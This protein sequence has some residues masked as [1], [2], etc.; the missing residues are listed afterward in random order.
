MQCVSCGT[1]IPSNASFCPKCG[2]K[3]AGSL[4]KLSDAAAPSPTDMLR[5]PD[6]GD[7]IEQTLW[8]GGYSGKAMIG[9]WLAGAI[10]TAG[11]IVAAVMFSE[12]WM[13]FAGVIAVIWVC[14]LFTFAYR[15]LNLHY[16]LTNQ[17]L[18]HKAGILTRR[19]D[20]IE[21]IDID[22][23][24]FEQGLIERMFGVGKIKISS[25]DR[26]H[27]EIVLIGIDDVKRVADLI[28]DARRTERR[29]RGIHIESV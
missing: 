20:R 7:D 4:A 21:A 15:R 2:A 24:T 14:L 23:V 12:W 18:I 25:S 9:S 11:L 13:I 6:V 28:D 1:E 3:A 10:L 27:P 5:R 29:K 26:T 19:S 16:D 8:S 22:D 17:R